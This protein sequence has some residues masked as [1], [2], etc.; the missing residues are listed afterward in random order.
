M[1]PHIGNVWG[2][3]MKKTPRLV[4]RGQTTTNMEWKVYPKQHC[5]IIIFSQ[6]Q[7]RDRETKVFAQTWSSQNWMVIGNAATLCRSLLP[8]YA[9]TEPS[10]ADYGG[11]ED[12]QRAWHVYTWLPHGEGWAQ[13][14]TAALAASSA[15]LAPLLWFLLIYA[16]AD[17][18]VDA[19]RIKKPNAISG[20]ESGRSGP[21]VILLGCASARS[22]TCCQ[23]CGGNLRDWEEPKQ[24]RDNSALADK[25]RCR[26]W[27]SPRVAAHC[28]AL[29]MPCRAAVEC[30]SQKLR[31]S[32]TK[33]LVLACLGFGSR[34]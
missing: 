26:G 22:H 6:P 19:D 23:R 11:G 30:S 5:S 16:N 12:S 10:K 21:R 33:L 28:V 1:H 2:C 27:R 3:G 34:S 9:S 7:P 32:S 17:E 20:F 31:S 8:S 13:M 25:K 15:T 29:T 14:V 18:T 4:K 24:A